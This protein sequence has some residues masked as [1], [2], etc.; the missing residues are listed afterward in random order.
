[1]KTLKFLLINLFIQDHRK[2]LEI[3]NGLDDSKNIESSDLKCP[4][5]IGDYL[6]CDNFETEIPLVKSENKIKSDNSTQVKPKTKKDE[7]LQ[8]LNYLKSKKEKKKQDKESIYTLELLL[9][10][11]K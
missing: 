10:N 11:M 5:Y 9:K 1:M 3:I 7:L 8:A 6:L 2:T 4:D